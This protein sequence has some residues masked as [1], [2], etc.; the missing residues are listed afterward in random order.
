MS[1]DR[2]KE[3]KE[4]QD[5]RKATKWYLQEKGKENGR[6][7]KKERKESRLYEGPLND[8]RRKMVKKTCQEIGRGGKRKD[9]LYKGQINDRTRKDRRYKV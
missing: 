3:Q 4:R 1:G 5:V 8:I 9:R 2:K 6:K 7:Q